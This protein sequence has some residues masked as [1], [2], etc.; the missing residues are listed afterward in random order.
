MWIIFFNHSFD[1]SKAS[2]KFKR[3]LDIID[4][5]V[6]ACSYLHASKLSA[7]TFDKLLHS[8][9]ASKWVP[10][11]LICRGMADAPRTSCSI[12]LVKA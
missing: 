7:H 9:M 10:L 8:L 1:F 12:I 2:H 6:L 3:A 11:V 5:I 4:T